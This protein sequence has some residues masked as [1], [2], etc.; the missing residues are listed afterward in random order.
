MS[1]VTI[2][3]R[4]VSVSFGTEIT[5]ADEAETTGKILEV[6][7]DTLRVAFSVEKT[8]TPEPNKVSIK[9]WNLNANNRKNASK[10]SPN[11]A[12]VVLKAGYLNQALK[13]VTIADVR[14]A[15]SDRDGADWVTTIEASEGG[16]AYQNSYIN[17]EFPAAAM[18]MDLMNVVA[19]FEK[20]FKASQ[21]GERGFAFSGDFD[22]TVQ[23]YLGWARSAV[24]T[25]I[26]KSEQQIRN[27]F[28]CSGFTHEMMTWL[29]NKIGLVWFFDN[30][31][32]CAY[33]VYDDRG[34]QPGLYSPD[35]GLIGPMKWQETG[36]FAFKHLLDTR[37]AVWSRQNVQAEYP[38]DGVGKMSA[39]LL[40]IVRATHQ[41]DTHGPEWT[42]SCD[43]VVVTTPKLPATPPFFQSF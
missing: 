42:T 11:K 22:A 2:P 14:Y 18:G 13:T 3:H 29:M 36:C 31:T 4:Q 9:I 35:T 25:D 33:P 28:A 1:T 40:K 6:K 41:G 37:L 34:N 8:H 10:L 39:K 30:N 19:E 16:L 12:L 43:A 15:E 5:N 27:G 32:L 23:A 17:K 7:P 20:S 38:D 24:D 26:G 21:T